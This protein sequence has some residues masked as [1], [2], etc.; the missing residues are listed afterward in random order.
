MKKKRRTSKRQENEGGWWFWIIDF[1]L[2]FVELII[3]PLKW[4]G[5]L[6]AGLFK[7]WWY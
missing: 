4:L 3:L 2:S 1:L 7:S 6:M 5:K